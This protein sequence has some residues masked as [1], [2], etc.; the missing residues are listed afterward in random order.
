MVTPRALG[1]RSVQ[2]EGRVHPGISKAAWAGRSAPLS[3]RVICD[4]IN[5]LRKRI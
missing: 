1:L 5:I 3:S 4:A 2:R